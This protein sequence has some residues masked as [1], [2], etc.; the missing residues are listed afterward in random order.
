MQQQ[1]AGRRQHHGP[2]ELAVWS[3]PPSLRPRILFASLTNLFFTNRST[4]RW[5]RLCVRYHLFTVAQLVKELLWLTN[6]TFDSVETAGKTLHVRVL[7]STTVAEQNVKKQKR[8]TSTVGLKR[9][10]ERL[11]NFKASSTI[12][13]E[14]FAPLACRP[15]ERWAS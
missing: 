4:N 5:R 7:L 8:E 10:E 1:A 12:T 11:L 13:E 15:A 2:C 6:Y 3:R 14:D 9:R